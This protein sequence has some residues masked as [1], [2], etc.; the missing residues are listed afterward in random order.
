[1]REYIRNE[2][3]SHID[4]ILEKEIYVDAMNVSNSLPEKSILNHIATCSAIT[5]Y[6]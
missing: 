1:M 4:V 2:F 3:I 5:K 6:T